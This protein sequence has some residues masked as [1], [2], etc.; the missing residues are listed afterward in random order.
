[1]AE[2]ILN[3]Q[4]FTEEALKSDKPILVDFWAEWCMPCRLISP[5]VEE[6]S[7]EFEGKLKVGKFNVDEN[8]I[9]ASTLRIEA[10]PTV[11]LFKDGKIFERFLGLQPKEN[12]LGAIKAA[13][14]ENNA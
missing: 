13:I 11:I 6:I 4:N 14:G 1:M 12:F 5:I 2:I 3:D 7:K 8:P 9:I 10:I